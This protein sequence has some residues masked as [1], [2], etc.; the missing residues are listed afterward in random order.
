MTAVQHGLR[1]L[2]WALVLSAG[3]WATAAQAHTRSE[4]LSVWEVQAQGPGLGQGAEVAV[5]VTVPVAEAQ[6]LSADGRTPPSDAQLGAYLAAHLG[7]RA[8]DQACPAVGAPVLPAAAAGFRRVELR[9]RCPQAAGLT[10][11]S[12]AFYE[13]VP[14]HLMYARVRERG[15]AGALAAGVPGQPAAEPPAD[16]FSEHLLSTERRSL[17]VGLDAAGAPAAHAAGFLSYLGLG[18]Q[19]ILTGPDHIAFLLGLVLVSA[20]FKDLALVVTGFTLGHSATLA[21][22]VTGWLRP[23]PALVDVVIALSIALVGAVTAARALAGA[24]PAARALAGAEPATRALSGAEPAAQRPGRRVAGVAAAAGLGLLALAGLRAAGVGSVPVAVWLGVAV[25]AP[26]Y[27]LLAARL[28][29]QGAAPLRAVVTAVFGLIHGFAFANDLIE[30][31]LPP[32]RLAELLLGFNLGVEAGQLVIVALWLAAG[33]ALQRV[34][35]AWH[36]ALPRAVLAEL[37]S[38]ALVGLGLFWLV[39]RGLA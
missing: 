30:M 12:D 4:S 32:G 19:H 27:L 25:F 5:T 37:L 39:G 15:A 18:L 38:S 33:W 28:P 1:G 10:L 14:T 24:E 3:V 21:L 6:R 11:H 13:Q 35:A 23:Q 34:A 31:Q 9:W 8:Q 2:A 29:A 17:A 20:R 26:C 22:A 16:R 36:R 7:A